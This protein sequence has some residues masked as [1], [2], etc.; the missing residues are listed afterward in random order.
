MASG[1]VLHIQEE[2][3]C[4]ICLG[5]LTEPLSLECGHSF[6][7]ACITADNK[8]PVIAQKEERLCPV[9]RFSYHPGDLRP[10]RTVA[11][12]VERL[13]E[14]KVSPEEGQK[15]DLCVRHGE[16]LQLFCK[17][18]GKVICWLCE[19]SQEHRGHHTLLMEEVAQEYQKK[20][21]A[22]LERLKREQK[23][24]EMYK[25][26]IRK[27]GASWKT[28]IQNEIQSFQNCIKRL[29]DILDIE[30]QKELQK[31]KK[32]EEN[33]LR[34]LAESEEELVQQSKLVSDLM[35]ALE[36]RLQGS[37]IGMVQDVNGIME[38]SNTLTVKE[39]YTP[40]HER[41]RRVLKPDLSRILKV[42]N[43]LK[44]D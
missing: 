41:R 8:E 15:R 9:C 38:R 18:D 30:E 5:L 13:R 25:N 21:G 17:E 43:E 6:C 28:Q 7:K 26:Y 40:S 14:V 11:N 22:A 33:V 24:T 19:R 12:I 27:E 36:H 34:T 35:S 31:L 23:K 44:D 20:L 32:T 1:I 16:K 29:K 37:A 4:P 3:T 42:L 10:N 39:P 2:L